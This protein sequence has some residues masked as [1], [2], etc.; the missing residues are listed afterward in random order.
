LKNEPITKD[1]F[2]TQPFITKEKVI[3]WDEER[4]FPKN[5]FDLRN[6]ADQLKIQELWLVSSL[7]F[8]K[9][10]YGY[11][12]TKENKFSIIETENK[13]TLKEYQQTSLQKATTKLNINPGTFKIYKIDADLK[14][15]YNNTPE[16]ELIEKNTVFNYALSLLFNDAVVV[17]MLY[18]LANQTTKS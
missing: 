5:T 1:S 13:P 8:D 3:E 17:D 4:R 10:K 7:G 2:L 15:L 14:E 12:S 18:E 16:N 11:Y 6:I 9:N